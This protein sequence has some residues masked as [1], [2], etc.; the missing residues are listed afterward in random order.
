[1]SKQLNII[2]IMVDQWRGDCIG[3]QGH[4]CVDTPN[5]DRLFAN[6][7]TFKQAY[8]AVPSCIAARAAL[9]TGMTQ[10]S[11][12]RVGYAE[13]YSWEYPNTLAGCLAKKGYHT[14]CVGKM[15]VA[16]ARNL[17]GFHSVELHDG[18]THNGRAH[19]KD[20]SLV[21]DYTPW[22]K[23]QSHCNADMI[24][25]GVGCNGYS[26]SPWTGE[27]RLH[28]SAWVV[29]KSIDFLRKRD[30]SKPFFLKMSFHRPHPPLDPPKYW[31]EHYLRKELPPLNMGEWSKDIEQF[32]RG[33]D[34][35]VPLK[36]DQIDLARRAYYA[37]LS[38][39][40]NQLNRMTHS[41]FEHEELNNTMIV[42]TSDHGDMLY[43]HNHVAKSNGLSASARIPLMIRTPED[44]PIDIDEPVELRDIMPTF[45][46]IAG[47][48]IPNSVEG[49]SLLP[50][51]QG[52]K[53]KWRKYIHGEHSAHAHSN[54]WI[55]TGKEMY[56]WYS[57]TGQEFY[58]DTENDPQ[59]INNLIK[60]RPK[61]ANILRQML[62]K[63]LTGREEGYV[64]DGQLVIGQAQKSILD[65]AG[66]NYTV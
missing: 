22:L 16:P 62:I 3:Y 46:D 25:S 11:H 24:D 45:L 65:E 34:S 32:N 39:I 31:L 40:D 53:P 1:M 2:L 35:P 38:F 52:E 37:Q 26:V 10:R 13:N 57:Q 19:K 14:H 28:P 56:M 60:E 48:T 41:L 36:A 47:A 20:Y 50:L 64:K 17:M 59:N 29:T 30:P 6:G 54:H 58:F 9:M 49:K 33:E 44:S 51:C 5:I 27:E 63:E 66:Y 8:T 55:N 7:A 4:P 61:Q 21:D 42:F 23:E 18:Y 12:G 15:H 43:D